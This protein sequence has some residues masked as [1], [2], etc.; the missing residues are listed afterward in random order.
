MAANGQETS[1]EQEEYYEED[2]EQY[3]NSSQH[4]QDETN[5]NQMDRSDHDVKPLKSSKKTP[6][7]RVKDLS[8][9]SSPKRD[10]SD[11]KNRKEDSGTRSKRNISGDN[12]QFQDPAKKAPNYRVRDQDKLLPSQERV[13]H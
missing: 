7:G 6:G 13:V 8:R 12:V 1:N 5:E 3:Q 10:G 4:S 9:Q 11:S 2:Q